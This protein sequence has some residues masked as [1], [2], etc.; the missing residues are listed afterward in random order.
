MFWWGPGVGEQDGQDPPG[1]HCP[2]SPTIAKM[3]LDTI[4]SI[5]QD[6][7]VLER[8]NNLGERRTRFF[9]LILFL[10]QICFMI[11]GGKCFVSLTLTCIVWEL[12]KK[13]CF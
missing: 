13:N 10:P 8:D 1:P 3:K 11:Q 12:G 5:G 9:F 6:S 4:V 2:S 7:V